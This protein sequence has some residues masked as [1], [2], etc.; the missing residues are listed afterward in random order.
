MQR[1]HAME[2]HIYLEDSPDLPLHTNFGNSETY[3]REAIKHVIDHGALRKGKEILKHKK[4]LCFIPC[5]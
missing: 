1:R 4:L 5:Q 2:I 3:A